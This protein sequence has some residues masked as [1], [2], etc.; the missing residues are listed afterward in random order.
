[1]FSI[2]PASW[3][4]SI[5]FFLAASSLALAAEHAT[6]QTFTVT[7][8]GDTTGTNSLRD[9][10]NA[11]DNGTA[12]AI[13]FNLPANSTIV[14]GS[15]LPPITK[16]VAITGPGANTLTIDGSTVSRVFMV[17]QGNVSISGVA[18]NNAMALGGSGAQGGGGGLGAGGGLFVNAG[19]TVNLSNVP[20]TNSLATGGS[21]G[22]T[23]NG[24][25]GGGGG[26]S[27][28]GG[29]GGGG[30]S[31]GGGGGGLY[32]A[33]GAGSGSS[34]GG[35]GGGGG[36]T[37]T[38]G[39]GG[40]GTGGGAGTAIAGGG[41]GGD[42]V[43]TANGGNGINTS[44]NGGGGSGGGGIQGGGGGGGGGLNGVTG[45]TGV[46]NVR[47]GA[48]GAGGAGGGGGGGGSGFANGPGGAGGDL[49]GGGGGQGGGKGGYGGGGGAS[50]NGGAGGAGGFGGGGG[51]ASG[52]GSS[53]GGSG[54]F[55]GA[56]GS[57]GGG[58]GAALGGAIFVRQ[59]GTLIVDGTSVSGG[60][61]IA[62]ISGG[63]GQP[64]QTQGTG[65]FLDG[66]TLNFKGS[67]NASIPDTIAGTGGIVQN[68]P[69]TLTLAGANSYSGGTTGTGGLINF[70]AANNFGT[71]LITLNGGGLQWA[72]GTSTDIS[73]S[74]APIGSGGATFDTNG[75][76][77]TFGTSV[78]GVG[79]VTKVGDGVLLYGAA[80][81]YLGGTT[82][83]GGTLRAGGVNF[84]PGGG[85]V[86]VNTGGTL[87]LNNFNQSIGGLNGNGGTVTLG[88]AALTVNTTGSASYA[89][90]I[91]GAGSLIMNGSGTQTLTGVN[92]FTGLSTIN[93]GN[94]AVNGSLAGPVLV[95]AGGMLSGTGSVGATTVNGTILPGD[96]LG[97]I[98]VNGNYVQNAGSTYVVQ[99]MPNGQTSLIKVNG[100][101]VINGGTA[102][103][104]ASP[105]SYFAGE[106]FAILTATGGVTGL[107]SQVTSN[108]GSVRFNEVNTGSEIDLIVQGNVR[109]ATN[110]SPLTFNQNAV[111]TV[112]S[113]PNL[114]PGLQRLANQFINLDPAQARNAL[115]QLSGA[116]HGSLI[117]Y[118][119]LDS[120]QTGQR[121]FDQLRRPVALPCSDT[122]DPCDP[123]AALQRPQGW[124]AWKVGFGAGGGVF[125]DGNASGYS[126]SS[127]GLLIGFD[128]WLSQTTRVGVYGGYNNSTLSLN[129]LNESA[130]LERYDIGLYGSQ[131]FGNFYL[132]SN[133]GYGFNHYTTSRNIA[134]GTL[135]NQSNVGYGGN[136]ANA[137]LETG[138]TEQYGNCL[139]QP[140]AGLQY[141]YLRN[142]AFAENGAGA[143]SVDG[144]AQSAQGLW[145]TLGGRVSWDCAWR[146]WTITPNAQARWINDMLG[147]NHAA[148]LQFAGGGA[149]FTVLGVSTGQN[150]LSTG[151]GIS[152]CF[153]DRFRLFGDYIA[154]CS[155]RETIH[156]GLGG[157]EFWW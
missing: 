154:L 54:T 35:G 27:G 103:V 89:G 42:G 106:K 74:L 7:S 73:G 142:N 94:L 6:A 110:F 21:G 150:F 133:A 8:T 120:M 107:Y 55:G 28:S 102:Q 49:G 121:L 41:G 52:G 43:G 127:G 85:D 148:A 81:T 69:S 29:A 80:M 146:Q 77:V 122:C 86:A 135:E 45:G 64:G 4:R 109:G 5:R 11:V 100:S 76:N 129:D 98:T 14:L 82:V 138:Y 1:M 24:F 153:N 134:F 40:S 119:Q 78:S 66:T 137:G 44:G 36:I 143:A 31:G 39:A 155:S 95:N 38:G 57:T 114:P 67:N 65:I 136:M 10:I 144:Q 18:V 53:P 83:N 68:G 117:S 3:R 104:L 132:L 92:T 84:L 13:N 128:R 97:T 87:D 101:A 30:V 99:V 141:M 17:M 48:G 126:V 130:G 51:S 15:S 123:C 26:L 59:G 56:A 140:L 91:Q 72:S 112:L 105:G 2:L 124:T 33:G 111:A 37:G 12:T 96:A 90:S 22:A 156:T 19:A 60:T 79:G 93:A 70:N 113:A 118:A 23:A 116:I 71:S 131:T 157:I 75:N 147:N 152:A 25:A 125:G 108:I 34:S 58:G 46:R 20:F 88:S 62:G 63:N 149:P 16:S 145:G 61:L 9:A 139:I 115:D 32:G 151:A 47:G 50:N